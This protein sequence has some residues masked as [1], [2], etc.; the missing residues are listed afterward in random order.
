MSNSEEIEIKCP[1]CGAP[2]MA[3]VWRKLDTE[4]D[5][6]IREALFGWEINIFNCNACDLRAQMP[7][8]LLYSDPAKRFAVQFYPMD[9]LGSDEFYEGFRRDGEPVDADNKTESTEQN[10]LTPHIVFDMAEMMRYIVFR[11][12]V[13]VKGQ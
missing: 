10:R 7:V 1:R 12:I 5:P 13:F 2:Q 8:S 4:A 6:G 11:E 3:T 9:D